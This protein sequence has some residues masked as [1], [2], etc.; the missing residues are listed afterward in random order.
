VEDRVVVVGGGA[1]EHAFARAFQAAGAAVITTPGNAGTAGVGRNADVAVDDVTGIVQLATAEEARLVFVG[2][3]R[4]LALGVVDAL[5]AARIPVFGPSRDA[6]RLESSKAFMKRFLERHGVPTAPFAVFDRVADAREYVV[7]AARPLV[8]KADG[9]AAGKGVVVAQTTREALDA[10]ERM[11]VHDAFG[12]AGRTIVIEEVLPGEEVSFHVVSDGERFA[13]LPPAQDHKR[14]FDDD[15][16]PNTGG[17]GAYAPAP[18]VTPRL[19]DA[20]IARIIEP[21]LAG[22]AREGTSFRGVLFAGIMVVDGEPIVLEFNV[23][24]GDPEATV[25]VPLLGAGG[26]SWLELLLGA[27]EGRLP[28]RLVAPS[29]DA[30]IAVVL[31][32]AGYPEAPATGDVISGLDLPD[33]PGTTVLHAGTARRADRAVVSAGGRVLTVTSVADSLDTAARQAYAA[34]SRIQLRGS[35]HRTDIGAR[36]LHAS[37]PRPTH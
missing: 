34:I 3:E 31:A 26:P 15:R 22:L 12:D 20:I 13:V 32:A 14:A 21:T 2:P 7:R 29:A 8:V 28:S 9:L 30:A 1:R 16:G 23:R 10:V 24:F 11:M 17:M 19:H 35:H 33:L 4:P 36:A 5:R 37:S 25:L 18:I 6:A 27:A